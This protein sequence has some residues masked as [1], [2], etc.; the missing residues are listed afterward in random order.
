MKLSVL[1]WGSG[2]GREIV[3]QEIP[4]SCLLNFNNHTKDFFLGP[5]W[6]YLGRHRTEL[7]TLS[8]DPYYGSLCKLEECG[9][10]VTTYRRM[11]ELGLATPSEWIMQDS[12]EVIWYDQ[13]GD[14]LWMH[15]HYE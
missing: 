12:M 9:F 3:D 15:N 2:S 10:I 1:S 13:S 5:A 4:D 14:L 6:K 11:C 8:N 7:E